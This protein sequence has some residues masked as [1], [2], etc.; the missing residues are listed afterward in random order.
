MNDP[1]R[2]SV[3]G[4]LAP[5]AEGFLHSLLEV[6]YTQDSAASQLQ[7][8]A[9]LSRWL[10]AEGLDVH[11]LHQNDLERFFHV[12]HRAGY[13]HNVSLKAMLPMLTYLRTQGISLSL[14]TIN[15]G[16]VDD[17]IGSYRHY[18]V[19][20]RGLAQLTVRRYTNAVRPFL[21]NELS[22]DATK[23]NWES[24]NA[25]RVT[26]FVVARTP[27]QSRSVAR[28]TVTALRSFLGYLYANGLIKQQL[29]AAVPAVAGWRLAALPKS[30][31]PR[32]VQALLATCDR[33]TRMGLRDFAVLTM[34]VRL[35]LRASE[36]AGLRLD[37]IDWR[38][39]SILIRGKGNQ[40]EPLPCP[41]DVGEA[42][43]AYLRRGR[44]ASAADR[45]VFVRIRAPHRAL[46]GIGVSGIVVAAARRAGLG[47]IRAHRLRHTVATQLLRAGSSLPEIGQLLRHR[48]ISTTAVYAKVDRDALRSIARPWPGGAA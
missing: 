43:V 18:L 44:P 38:A 3:F 29:T 9:H 25:A 48:H 11:S 24:L 15:S 37:D 13:T 22:T 42:V 21:R 23:I 7:L 46:S 31:Q 40:I 33:R 41:Q 4:P 16:P 36:L 30:L 5:F 47:E 10:V 34:L 12:R 8:I 35:G 39:G 19:H 45:S 1:S 27:S 2:V 17:A 6:G 14:S 32:E 26:A 28:T 20:E